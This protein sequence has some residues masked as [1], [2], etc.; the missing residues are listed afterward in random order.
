M[1]NYSLE[2]LLRI[3][4]Y[5]KSCAEQTLQETIDNQ[6][7]EERKLTTI[8]K[9]IMDSKNVRT[10]IADSFFEK[11]R[12]S[13]SNG[14]DIIT[15]IYS[16]QKII[17]QEE[18]LRRDFKEQAKNV[19]NA[20]KQHQL[21]MQKLQIAHIDLK[22]VDKHHASWQQN[23]KRTEE[24]SAQYEADDQNSTRFCIKKRA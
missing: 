2:T 9:K 13:P 6:E 21:A 17:Y 15:L 11:T 8:R 4:Q 12:I 3:R 22:V 23:I 16:A 14:R 10:K 24:L 7:S 1:Q 20:K 18:S 5:D 19:H